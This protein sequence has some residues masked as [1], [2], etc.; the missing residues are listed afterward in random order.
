MKERLFRRLIKK[1][2]ITNNV[3]CIQWKK[4]WLSPS[5]ILPLLGVHVKKLI[6]ISLIDNNKVGKSLKMQYHHW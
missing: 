3:G 6:V 1:Y 2:T 4:K 5:A